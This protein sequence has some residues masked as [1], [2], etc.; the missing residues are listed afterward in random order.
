M[1]LLQYQES[2]IFYPFPRMRIYCHHQPCSSS[3]QRLYHNIRMWSS[4]R[5]RWSI[6]SCRFDHFR[7]SLTWWRSTYGMVRRR[8]NPTHCS[9]R[10]EKS[11][12][13]NKNFHVRKSFCGRTNP[14]ETLI[15]PRQYSSLIVMEQGKIILHHSI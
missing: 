15:N 11:T 5:R 1:L 12:Y 14:N 3:V 2:E 8:K 10:L 9:C 7:R 13:V 4:I 6:W